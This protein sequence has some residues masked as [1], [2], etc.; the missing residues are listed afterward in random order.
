MSNDK[1]YEKD[2]IE[3]DLSCGQCEIEYSVFT[4][5]EGYIEQAR[6]CPFCG[7]Y[8]L[9]YDREDVEE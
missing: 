8:N 5:I 1:D 2:I 6:Y 7:A 9:D 4:R 3:I